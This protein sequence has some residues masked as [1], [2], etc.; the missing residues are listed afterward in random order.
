MDKHF[1]FPEG[2]VWFEPTPSRPPKF[3]FGF[4]VKLASGRRVFLSALKAKG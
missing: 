3:T 1:G 2:S 4:S